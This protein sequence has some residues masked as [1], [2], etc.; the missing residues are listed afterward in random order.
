MLMGMVIRRARAARGLLL[1]ATGA[2]LVATL[3]LTGLADYGRDVVEAGAR[4]VVDAARP[5]E[6]SLLVQG[7]AGTFSRYQ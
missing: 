2:T 5:Q 1:A 4:G 6:R 7:A 3:L